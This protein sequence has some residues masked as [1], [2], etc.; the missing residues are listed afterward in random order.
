V[1][2][3]LVIFAK[4]PVPGRVKTRLTTE[5]SPDGA[6]EV[7]R[8][9]LS[10]VLSTGQKTRASRR[11][12]Q[13]ADAGEILTEGAESFGY[14][15]RPQASGDLGARL[16]AAVG[17]ACASG[18]VVVLGTD[19]PTLPASAVDEAFAQLEAGAS[20]VL[21]PST[22]G[23]YT[24]IGMDRLHPVVFQGMPWS[25]SSLL[26]AT[27]RAARASRLKTALL[28][29]WYDIDTPEDLRW[30]SAHLAQ[31]P[32]LDA[33]QTRK[34]LEKLEETGFSLA[35]QPGSNVTLEE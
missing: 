1:D 30:L 23:G 7:Y 33:P 29:F 22:D 14:E 2:Q 3:T 20:L 26:T 11:V 21:G 27:L 9:F 19:A 16:A 28:P 5:L 12:L 25:E 24:L 35:P 17:E 32:E 13:A 8:A 34:I 18:S 6:A 4:E 31:S 15:L 10:D